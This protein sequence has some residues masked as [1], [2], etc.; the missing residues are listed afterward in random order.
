MELKETPKE[1][2]KE[3]ETPSQKDDKTEQIYEK[4]K[5]QIS[6]RHL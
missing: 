6:H 1:P 2:V 3:K 5:N 4:T